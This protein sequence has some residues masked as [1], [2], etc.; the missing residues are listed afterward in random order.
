ML[1]ETQAQTLAEF[2]SDPIELV[3]L[4]TA[5]ELVSQ[6]TDR[7]DALGVNTKVRTEP[8]TPLTRVYILEDN[9]NMRAQ[10]RGRTRVEAFT[11]AVLQ[12]A[13]RELEKAA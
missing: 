12:F 9:G 1:N 11:A 10:G 2:L 8:R 3:H 4:A 6:I 7:F 5:G 13:E